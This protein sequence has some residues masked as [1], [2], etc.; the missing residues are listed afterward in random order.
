MRILTHNALQPFFLSSPLK[1]EIVFPEDRKM[2]EIKRKDGEPEEVPRY[3]SDEAITGTVK[4]KL[5]SS[6]KVE[7][8]GISVTL[9]GQIG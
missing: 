8:Y 5:G 9:V 1:A 3:Y 6:K 4:V 7:H 2:L